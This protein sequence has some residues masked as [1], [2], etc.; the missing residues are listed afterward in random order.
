VLDEQS[1]YK[2]VEESHGGLEDIGTL[3]KQCFQLS[4]I[5]KLT[6]SL[7]PAVAQAARYQGPVLALHVAVVVPPQGRERVK[8]V[9]WASQNR[10]S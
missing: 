6:L 9:P 3:G 10:R 5:S 2:V 1:D 4:E 8:R 7:E